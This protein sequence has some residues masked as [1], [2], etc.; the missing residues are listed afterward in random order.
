MEIQI[1]VKE[2]KKLGFPRNWGRY[3][4]GQ[5]AD[6]RGND[7]PSSV[8]EDLLAGFYPTEHGDG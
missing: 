6:D 1:P 5:K 3:Y 4:L 2:A 7:S 8:R